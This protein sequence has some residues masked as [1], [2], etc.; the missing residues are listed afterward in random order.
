VG[1]QHAGRRIVVG[2]EEERDA[3]GVDA[4]SAVLR[5]Q[6]SERMGGDEVAQHVRT[7]FCEMGG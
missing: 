3:V 7:H 6:Q 2:V 5:H 1:A 4:A